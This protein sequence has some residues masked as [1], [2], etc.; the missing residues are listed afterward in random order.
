MFKSA[1][2][3]CRKIWQTKSSEQKLFRKKLNLK[4]IFKKRKKKKI[5]WVLNR[6]EFESTNQH[7]KLYLEINCKVVIFVALKRLLKS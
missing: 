2:Q 5:V 1:N 7:K 6:L 3:H 4:E